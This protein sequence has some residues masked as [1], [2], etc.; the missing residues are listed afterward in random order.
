M[1]SKRTRKRYNKN[2][3]IIIIMV[4]MIGVIGLSIGFSAFSKNLDINSTA[5]VTPD[6][7]DFKVLF[8]TDVSTQKNGNVMGGGRG[9]NHSKIVA[10]S[11]TLTGT[12]ISGLSAKFTEPNQ[13]VSYIFYARNEGEYDAYLNS[14]NYANVANYSAPIKCT[15]GQGTSPTLVDATCNGIFVRVWTS[16]EGNF[17]DDICEDGNVCARNKTLANIN[18][19]MLAKNSAEKITVDILYK[20]DAAVADGDFTIEVGNITLTYSTTDS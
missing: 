14:I 15:P 4:L 19:H 12:Q 3:K 18:N 20:Y 2:T 16:D 8:S 10:G 7:S 17:F 1:N 9:N 6:S 11:A 5:T 13:A